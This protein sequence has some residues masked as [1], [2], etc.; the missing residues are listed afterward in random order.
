MRNNVILTVVHFLLY[1]MN[2]LSMHERENIKVSGF[3]PNLVLHLLALFMTESGSSTP[4][5]LPFQSHF[6][7]DFSLYN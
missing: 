5:D 7:S 2:L 4:L 6:L 1:C 3:I